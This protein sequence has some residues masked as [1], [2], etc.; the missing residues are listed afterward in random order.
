MQVGRQAGLCFLPLEGAR[1][2]T[3]IY[4]SYSS[5]THYGTYIKRLT[6]A[7]LAT[8]GGSRADTR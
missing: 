5:G 1:F 8:V 7:L 3:D 6:T 2:R 4:M